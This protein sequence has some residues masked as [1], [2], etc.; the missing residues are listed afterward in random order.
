MKED[1]N[2]KS[3]MDL[4]KSLK[5]EATVLIEQHIELV[6]SELS[7][8][9]AQ[10]LEK[11]K[12]EAST[13]VD[14]YIQSA[15]RDFDLIKIEAQEKLDKA[16]KNLTYISAG[17]LICQ[18]GFVVLLISFALGINAALAVTPVPDMFSWF[19]PLIVGFLAALVG[20]MLVQKGKHGIQKQSLIPDKSIRKMKENQKWI[21]KQMPGSI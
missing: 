19:G 12:S 16:A 6:K 7:E 4:V 15:K 3:T 21:T 14:G 1:F 10:G 18:S 9:A 5:D 8:E 13:F 11:L 20:F 17:S 2:N